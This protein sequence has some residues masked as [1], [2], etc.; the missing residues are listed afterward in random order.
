MGNFEEGIKLLKSA[1]LLSPND[2][3]LKK[4]LNNGLIDYSGALISEEKY[5]QAFKSLKEAILIGSKGFITHI[6]RQKT[7]TFS[8]LSFLLEPTLF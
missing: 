4:N 7:G 1:L 3:N 6:K 5:K 8:Y 2:D